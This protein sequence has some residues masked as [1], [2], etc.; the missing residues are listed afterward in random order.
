LAEDWG[1]VDL[2]VYSTDG[3]RRY[4]AVL[5]PTAEPRWLLTGSDL[6]AL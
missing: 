6:G 2:A 1:I 3:G 4:A 5:E